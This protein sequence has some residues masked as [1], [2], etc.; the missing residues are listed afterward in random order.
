[1][2][3]EIEPEIKGLSGILR[4]NGTFVPCDYNNH[5]EAAAEIPI[6]EQEYCIYLSSGETK[7]DEGLSVIYYTEKPTRA[8]MLWLSNHYNE[9]DLKQKYH[10]DEYIMKNF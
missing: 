2:K 4:P 8:Q 1:M 3:Q 6:E 5:G 7:N 9:L 10:Y